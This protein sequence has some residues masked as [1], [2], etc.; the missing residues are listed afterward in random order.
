MPNDSG[1]AALY[2]RS[3]KDRTDI[4]PATQRH[5]L[6]QL[7][8]SHSLLVARTY[9]DAVESGSTEDRPAFS[10]LLRDLKN[11]HRGWTYL[12]VYDTSRLARRRYIAQ[13][14]KHECKKRGITI[15]YATRPADV[16]PISEIVL[17]SMLEAMD[18]VHSLMSRQKGLAGMAENVRQGFRA[19]GRAPFGYQLAVLPTGAIREGRAVTKSKLELATSAD[20]VRVYLKARADG[21]PRFLAIKQSGI[22]L[23]ATSLIGVEWNALT[24]AG[25]TVWNV[26]REAGSGSKRR[27]RSEWH[28]KPDT[29]PALITERE[30]EAI[31]TQLETSSIGA[32]IRTSRAA[33]SRF[34]LSGLLFS[35]DGRAWL[36]HGEHYRLRREYGLPGRIVPAVKLDTAIIETLDAF[37]RTPA[38][39]ETLLVGA[40]G[41]R[42]TVQPGG[43][44]LAQIRRL[45]RERQRAAEKA[46]E[47]ED[48]RVFEELIDT[49]GRQIAALQREMDAVEREAA[50]GDGLRSL[51][52]EELRDLIGSQDPTKVVRTLIERVVLEPTLDCQIRVRQAPYNGLWRS[53]ASP[54]GLEPQPQGGVLSL[55]PG[56]WRLAG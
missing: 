45:E 10:Q 24:Y 11:A 21:V 43:E 3:S 31:V 30:A 54:R 34:L 25:H 6:E 9:E 41:Q 2:L 23:P 26:H 12:L 53:V 29:H 1:K 13:A 36:G 51:G 14:L 8:A 38:Y 5:A 44:I 46:V 27:P 17:D 32:A 15:L 20:Q 48:G 35:T 19:G 37:R 33:S 22:Q 47:V 7:A 52:I 40:N 42:R 16:D 28:I 55:A 18:E 39:L 56:W 4:S 50:T 49:K